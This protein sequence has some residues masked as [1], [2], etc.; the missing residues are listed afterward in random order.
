MLCCMQI[1]DDDGLAAPG[2]I[3]RPDYI[4]I[5]KQSPVVTRGPI[6]SPM[7]LPD[8]FMTQNLIY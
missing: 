6:T 3:V 2:E 1:L 7:G 5:N 4:Y 8:R